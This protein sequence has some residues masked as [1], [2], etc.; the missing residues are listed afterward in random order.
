MPPWWAHG[1]SISHSEALITS[2]ICQVLNYTSVV[3][4]NSSKFSCL[5]RKKHNVLWTWIE[6]GTSRPV[7]DAL[8]ITPLCLYTYHLLDLNIPFTKSRNSFFILSRTGAW[9]YYIDLGRNEHIK[10]CR[11]G[12]NVIQI[13]NLCLVGHISFTLWIDLVFGNFI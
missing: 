1:M 7:S 9:N 13:C 10:A 4:S 3:W 2:L 8:T 12:I 11:Y 6:P 5:S